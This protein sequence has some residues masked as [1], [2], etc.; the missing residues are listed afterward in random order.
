[1]R[2]LAV[3][4]YRFLTTNRASRWILAVSVGGVLFVAVL[5]SAVGDALYSAGYSLLETRVRQTDPAMIISLSGRM[6]AMIYIVHVAILGVACHAFGSRDRRSDSLGEAD[7]LDTAPVTPAALF[8]G[9]AI[10]IFAST[11]AVHLATLPLLAF[12]F[13]L[14][15][16]PSISFVWPEVVVVALV[17]L[18]SLEASWKLHTSRMRSGTARAAGSAAALFVLIF[19][20]FRTLTTWN[21]FRDALGAFLVWPSPRAWSAITATVTSPLLLVMTLVVIY[22]GFTLF[23]YLRAVRA[24]EQ[25]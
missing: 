3:G 13:L 11:M 9:D 14:G 19:I 21:E 22:A 2:S 4:R 24:V 20:T 8:W 1:M 6:L 5:I 15:P 25:G 23:Y 18:Q 7:L 17:A 12:A 10:G 16:F